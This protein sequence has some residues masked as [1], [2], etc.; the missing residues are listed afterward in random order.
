MRLLSTLCVALAFVAVA[1]AAPKKP[2]GRQFNPVA[3]Y[4]LRLTGCL[5]QRD[6]DAVSKNPLRGAAEATS[7]ADQMLITA[8]ALGCGDDTLSLALDPLAY[9][10]HRKVYAGEC[11]AV[12]TIA[13]V[14]TA[15]DARAVMK[16]RINHNGPFLRGV[17][18]AT[19]H[20]DTRLY[21][22]A[23]GKATPED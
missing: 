4:D 7:D 3:E 2:N 23:R 1:V 17:I 6:G 20:D 15:L 13:D 16:V 18:V 14:D 22:E 9:R 5:V 19:N 11:S 21:L 10:F 12:A 8:D